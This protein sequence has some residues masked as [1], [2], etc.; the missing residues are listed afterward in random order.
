M[1]I[2][3]AWPWTWKTTMVKNIISEEAFKS[4]IDGYAKFPFYELPKQVQWVW[5]QPVYLRHPKYEINGVKVG[6]MQVLS[7]PSKQKMFRQMV[8]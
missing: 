7:K 8:F 4:N 2:L 5:S 6:R 3:L 1:K